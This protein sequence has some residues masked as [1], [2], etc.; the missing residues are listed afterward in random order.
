MIWRSVQDQDLLVLQVSVWCSLVVVMLHPSIVYA[1]GHTRG[2][3]AGLFKRRHAQGRPL[4]QVD[5]SGSGQTSPEVVVA[6]PES[7]RPPIRLMKKDSTKDLG[8]FWSSP[9]AKGEQVQHGVGAHARWQRHDGLRCMSLY[10]QTT[11]PGPTSL[12]MQRGIAPR[13]CVRF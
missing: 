7:P 12:V 8:I 2:D 5:V 4:S 9:G 10:S 1:P 11:S 6:G 3:H 13:T